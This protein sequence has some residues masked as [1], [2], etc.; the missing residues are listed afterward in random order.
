MTAA[1]PPAALSAST[2]TGQP[3]AARAAALTQAERALYRRILDSFI[4]GSPVSLDPTADDAAAL[5]EAD[6]IQTDGANHIAV[7]YP[8][9]ARPT[10]HRVAMHDGRDYYAMCAFDAL[11]IPHMLHERGEVSTREPDGQEVVRVTVDP[12]AE[13]TWMPTRAVAVVASGEGCCLAQS[14]CLH[15]NLFASADAAARY[16][17]TH[18]LEGGTLSIADAAI[19]GRWLFADLLDSVADAAAVR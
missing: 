2:I 13:P 4:S 14:A 3:F 1:T 6:L 11:G 12:T 7:A 17:D 5:I 16:L 15:I 9:S 18:A 19:V 10:R 8:F